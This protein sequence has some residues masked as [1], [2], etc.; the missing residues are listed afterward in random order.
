MAQQTF[1]NPHR[2]GTHRFWCFEELLYGGSIDRIASRLAQNHKVYSGM[3][4]GN[5]SLVKRVIYD[6][7]CEGYIFDANN[8]ITDYDP[9]SIT[10][11][12]GHRRNTLDEKVM[13]FKLNR[14]PFGFKCPRCN[15][16]HKFPHMGGRFPH[17]RGKMQDCAKTIEE[18]IARDRWDN[19]PKAKRRSYTM[20][21]RLLGALASSAGQELK[22]EVERCLEIRT[23]A[24]KEYYE[25]NSR[26]HKKWTDEELLNLFF[27]RE[28]FSANYVARLT[29][30][31]KELVRAEARV[32]DVASKILKIVRKKP[33]KVSLDLNE[34]GDYKGVVLNGVSVSTSDLRMEPKGKVIGTCSQGLVVEMFLSDGDRRLGCYDWGSA[35]GLYP[36]IDFENARWVTGGGS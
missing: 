27:D 31:K 34:Y 11:S 12:G 16:R 7:E 36:E 5:Y 14:T 26:F 19:T 17:R 32:T 20:N 15:K 8:M 13:L 25:L 33:P 22:A 9:N 6:M 2:P 35:L 1:T 3:K 30:T 21:E 4:D 18:E 28:R 29:S 24:G 10:A 23:N